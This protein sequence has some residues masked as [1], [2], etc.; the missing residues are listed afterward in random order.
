MRWSFTAELFRWDDEGP[1]W[2]FIRVPAELADDVRMVAETGGFG[3]V[4]VAATVGGTSWSTSLFPEKATDSY[5]L[6]VKKQVRDAEGL[7]DGDLVTVELM[8]ADL[9]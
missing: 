4:K 6:P 9:G 1:S 2:R 7:D 3:S 5:L 8:L